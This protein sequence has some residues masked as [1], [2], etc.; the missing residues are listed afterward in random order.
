MKIETWNVT[1]LKNNYRIGI[2]IDEFRPFELDLSGVSETP[3]VGSMKLG[4]IEFV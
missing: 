4:N 2:L 1:K 3:G